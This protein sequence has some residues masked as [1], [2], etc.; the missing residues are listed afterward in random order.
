MEVGLYR[1][2]MVRV[3]IDEKA[4]AEMTPNEIQ[5]FQ[6]RRFKN[7]EKAKIHPADCRRSPAAQNIGSC[8]VRCA[9]QTQATVFSPFA[10]AISELATYCFRNAYAEVRSTPRR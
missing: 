6:E 7:S 5:D 2:S 8:L 1:P 10:L 9:R 3:L 4:L